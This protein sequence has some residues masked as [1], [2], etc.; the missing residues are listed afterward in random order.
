ML[1]SLAAVS[2]TRA[3]HQRGE[4][5]LASSVRMLLC[6]AMRPASRPPRTASTST[7]W[8]PDQ[9]A[10]GSQHAPRRTRPH[11]CLET[12]SRPR[13]PSTETNYLVVW[14]DA[15]WADSDIYGA[16]VSPGGTVL[17]PSGIAIST[18]AD[19]QQQLRRRL[20]RDELPRRLA[21]DRRRHALRH[22]RRAREPRRTV[23]DPGGIA[24]STAP[25][26]RARPR[27]RS[28]ARTTSSPGRSTLGRRPT[29]STA[30]A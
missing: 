15:R 13:S 8:C 30:R 24:I 6:K 21:D 1:L 11:A 28:T 2:A 12:S 27:S 5:R 17:D 20:R 10:T 16:R 4:L 25:G 23:L 19:V 26:F 14:D 22:L 9:C 7:A 3:H 18:A 29:T